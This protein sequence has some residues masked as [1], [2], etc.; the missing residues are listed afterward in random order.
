LGDTAVLLEKTMAEL[1]W[2]NDAGSEGET[3]SHAKSFAFSSG[4]MAASSIIL[5]HR[6]PVTVLL[7]PDCY[8]GVGTVLA[9]VFTRFQVEV[10]QVHMAN[11][12]DVQEAIEQ[13]DPASQVIVWI[14]TPSNPLCQITDI[15]AV[16]DAVRSVDR[17]E[18]ITTM[19]DSTLSP[20]CITQALSV[21]PFSYSLVSVHFPTQIFL[22]L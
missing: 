2:S 17:K 4:M 15:R 6:A 16:C 22:R 13:S 11:I 5:A 9:D 21:R 20:P 19:V 8:H 10:V 18:A 1:E 3:A 14:E 7:P 12:L